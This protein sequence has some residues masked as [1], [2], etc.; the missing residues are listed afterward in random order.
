LT[1]LQIEGQAVVHLEVLAAIG[2]GHVW[3]DDHRHV[4]R[5]Q[6]TAPLRDE[7]VSG[8]RDTVV[9]F[10]GEASVLAN[11][12]AHQR[13]RV[14]GVERIL[15]PTEVA[16]QPALHSLTRQ[17]LVTR[18]LARNI[19]RVTQARTKSQ[20]PITRAKSN[21]FAKSAAQRLSDVHL[22]AALRLG[23]HARVHDD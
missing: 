20:P 22:E 13:Q 17:E 8:D 11:I 14:S 15:Q 6:L 3:L 21:S 7:R 23:D 1:E 19:D 4:D 18:E 9:L 12:R 16:R 2:R 5:L 10:V